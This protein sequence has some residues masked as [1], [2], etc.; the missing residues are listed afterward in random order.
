MTGVQTCALPICSTTAGAACPSKSLG[1]FCQTLA[2]VLVSCACAEHSQDASIRQSSPGG[3][4][5]LQVSPDA[6]SIPLGMTQQLFATGR[7]SDGTSRDMT[8][9]VTWS[10]F[11]PSVAQITSN[12]IVLPVGNGIAT[13]MARVNS[14]TSQASVSVIRPSIEGR[15]HEPLPEQYIWSNDASSRDRTRFFRVN[16]RV[17]RVPVVSTLYVAGPSILTAYLNGRLIAD[18]SAS[19]QLLTNPFVLHADAS[20]ALQ[21]GQNLLALACSNANSVVAKI[22]PDL[23][24]VNTLPLVVSDSDWKVTE[25]PGWGW[26]E[27]G[28]DATAWPRVT[29]IGNVESNPELTQGGLDSGMYQWPGYDGIAPFLARNSISAARVANVSAGAGQFSNLQALTEPSSSAG[30][31]VRMARTL[32]STIDY[33]SLILDFG[34]EI[35]GRLEVESGASAPAKIRLRYGESL[36][37]AIDQP[38]YG[39]NELDVPP[40]T[41]VYGPKSGFRYVQVKFVSGPPILSFEKLQAEEIFYPVPYKG[42]FDSSDVLLNRIWSTGA[43]TAHLTMQ[44]GIWDGIKRDRMRWMGDFFVSGRVIQSIFADRVL[45][46]LTLDLLGKRGLGPT[47]FVNN[48]P[49]YSAFWLMGLADYYRYSGEAGFLRAQHDQI[50]ILLHNME[51]AIDGS[52]LLVFDTSVFPFVDWSPDFFTDTPETR[53]ATQFEFYR[54]FSDGAWLLEELEDTRGA[55]DAR[56][57]AGRLKSAAQRFL[58]NSASNT[59]GSRWQTNAAAIFSLICDPDQTDSIWQTVLSSPSS[60][61]VTPYYNYFVIKAMARAGHRSEALNWMRAY[62][63]GMLAEGATAFWEA[64]DLSWPKDNFHAFLQA[65]RRQGYYVS[66][67][68]GWSSGP[69][70]WLMEEVLGIQPLERGF[71]QVSIRPDLADLQW[72]RGTEP[73]PQGNIVVSYFADS[74]LSGEITL[75]Y[76]LQAFL[77]LPVSQGQSSVLINGVPTRGTSSESGTRIVVVLDQ[78]GK[79]KFHSN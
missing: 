70:A 78:P 13:I 11:Q 10:S 79:Y 21:P 22:V 67:A 55:I 19:P 65:D 23:P 9:V 1:Y 38:F 32:E 50:S 71:K 14:T 26:M 15:L 27:P 34:R 42:F 39:E 72:A 35:S 77:S 18:A 46:R 24:G 30:F 58:L 76:H 16:F 49:G 6:T 53:A 20:T 7:F 17:Q 66:L 8:G 62:W 54:A 5:S 56:V 68:H 74:V 43:R 47:G 31:F 45:T 73:T 2:I 75:P 25:T 63:G 4:E 44:A 48:I 33:P 52:G 57:T 29:T 28:Y 12:G 51:N 40:R 3:L 61:S 37:E 64:Y 59:Y 41:T 36:Q 69:T 60:G